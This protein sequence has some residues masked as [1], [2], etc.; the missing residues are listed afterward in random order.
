[1]RNLA[2]ACGPGFIFVD[3]NFSSQLNS[4]LSLL[5][6]SKYSALQVASVAVVSYF[7]GLT[8]GL[9]YALESRKRSGDRT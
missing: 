3:D 7:C 5:S 8:S 1:M 6:F 9:E 4:S 2:V